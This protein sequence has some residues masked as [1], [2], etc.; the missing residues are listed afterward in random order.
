[1]SVRNTGGLDFTSLP[2]FLFTRP[3]T[4][5]MAVK[6]PTRDSIN[7]EG[8]LFSAYDDD[9]GGEN[10]WRE[11]HLGYG[12]PSA[13]ER[14]GN[15]SAPDGAQEFAADFDFGEYGGYDYSWTWW[16]LEVTSLTSRTLRCQTAKQTNTAVYNTPPSFGSM[17]LALNMHEDTRVAQAHFLNGSISDAQWSGILA[18]T[19]SIPALSG[20][21]DGFEFKNGLASRG[22]TMTLAAR[23][24]PVFVSDDPTVAGGTVPPDP[25]PA[26]KILFAG[27]CV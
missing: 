19:Q 12:Y 3:C 11:M 16:A 8:Y 18:G 10:G 22:G 2:A 25:A 6:Y 24:T 14:G 26:G 17:S 7:A 4:V 27:M 20:Y 13:K 23:G 9:G 5:I 15:S 1:M 21:V